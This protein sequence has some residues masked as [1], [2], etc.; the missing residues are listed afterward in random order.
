MALFFC[1]FILRGRPLAALIAALAIP[2]L[3]LLE[4]EY[5]IPVVSPL[6]TKTGGNII[7][8]F[9]AP[10]AVRELIFAA[11]YDTK[12]D[13]FDHIQRAKIYTGIPYFFAL[14]VLMSIW[15]FAAKKFQAL[16]RP[17][18]RRIFIVF[19]VIFAAYWTLTALAF[20]GFIFI[21]RQSPGAV[22]NAASVTALMGLARDINKGKVH[23]GKSNVSILLTCGEEVHLQG[24]CAYVGKFIRGG[25]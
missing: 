7:I 9:T 16:N 22:D 14:G 3:L 6:V 20:G 10:D 24:A 1:Y 19:P 25:D 13:F 5:F 18:I 15:V 23:I 17:A 8:N 4:F 2:V 12:T 21:S 11:H